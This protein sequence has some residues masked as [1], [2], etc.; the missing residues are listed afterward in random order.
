MPPLGCG[1]IMT[2][3]FGNGE[4]KEKGNIYLRHGGAEPKNPPPRL[5]FSL[6]SFLPPQK[7]QRRWLED[8]LMLIVFQLKFLVFTIGIFFSKP[9]FFQ[10]SKSALSTTSEWWR[11]LAKTCLWKK[12][13]ST[14]SLTGNAFRCCR[15]I[16]YG[17]NCCVHN[18]RCLCCF[19][20]FKVLFKYR[21]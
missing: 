2:M 13:K 10:G 11:A 21:Y 17:W 7:Q 20:Y 5:C 8:L 18:F 6:V 3:N 1:T 15:A 14:L 16:Q 19:W 12:C 4:R 9:S